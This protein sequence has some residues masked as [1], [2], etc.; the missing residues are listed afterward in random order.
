MTRVVVRYVRC[1]AFSHDSTQIVSCGD[2]T[3]VQLWNVPDGSSEHVFSN[4]HDEK[5]M[6]VA[7]SPD[8]KTFGACSSTCATCLDNEQPE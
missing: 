1:C 5:V 6:A 7:F 4:A 3:S 8:N 2:D